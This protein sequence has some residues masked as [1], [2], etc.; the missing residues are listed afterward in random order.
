VDFINLKNLKNYKNI[1]NFKN[2]IIKYYFIIDKYKRKNNKMNNFIKNFIIGGLIV[3]TAEY[4]I[5][6]DTNNTKYVA[7]MVH[8]M[9]LAFLSTYLLLNNNKSEQM[10]IKYGID[11]SIII[12]LSMILL[13]YLINSSNEILNNK[14]YSTLI[15]ILFWMLCIYLY[16]NNKTT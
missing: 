11:I 8:G 12:V 10:L 3:S 4:F 2:I 9:P 7:I 1:N 14:Y 5:H 13:Y 6:K 16:L 15:T